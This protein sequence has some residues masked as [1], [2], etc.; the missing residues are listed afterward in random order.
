MLKLLDFLVQ[1]PAWDSFDIPADTVIEIMKVIWSGRKGWCRSDTLLANVTARFYLLGQ[2]ECCLGCT[3]ILQNPLETSGGRMS[4]VPGY[5]EVFF[6]CSSP[7]RP[8]P[9]LWIL[10][11]AQQHP[12]RRRNTQLHPVKSSSLG[13]CKHEKWHNCMSGLM[14]LYNVFTNP[15]VYLAVHSSF[16]H[17]Y[18]YPLWSYAFRVLGK[19]GPG[20]P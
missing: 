16:P 6:N 8:V 1:L 14:Q 5:Y 9:D 11:K 10:Q 7:W 4:D 20:T 13:S 15:S 2:A 19:S 17:P 3:C 18:A 12:I